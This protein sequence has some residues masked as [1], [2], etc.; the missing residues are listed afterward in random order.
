MQTGSTVATIEYD[1]LNRRTSKRVANSGD[2]VW[3]GWSGAAREEKTASRR[4][5]QRRPGRRGGLVQAG[6]SLS[7]CAENHGFVGKRVP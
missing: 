6:G 2:A 1:G 4:D 5:D 3:D 7:E